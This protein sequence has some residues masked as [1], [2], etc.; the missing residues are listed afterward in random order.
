M[1]FCKKQNKIVDNHI[2][3]CNKCVKEKKSGFE[4][5]LICQNFNLDLLENDINNYVVD[6]TECK[7]RGEYGLNAECLLSP[8]CLKTKE[9]K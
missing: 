6:C 3:D 9:V 8:P 4:D 2:R 7:I 5:Q 1:Y